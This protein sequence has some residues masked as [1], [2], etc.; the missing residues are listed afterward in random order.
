[1]TDQPAHGCTIDGQ[2]AMPILISEHTR[3]VTRLAEAEHLAATIL[4]IQ[5]LADE[6]PVAIPTHL[7]EAALDTNRDQ[8]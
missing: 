7:I 1:M 6:H 5:H 2:P 8:P 4:R 3:L